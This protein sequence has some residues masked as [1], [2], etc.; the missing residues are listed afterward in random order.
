MLRANEV[1]I[2]KW[3]KGNSSFGSDASISAKS[4]GTLCLPLKECTPG[5]TALQNHRAKFDRCCLQHTWFQA[6]TEHIYLNVL[7][8]H[9]ALEYLW[10]GKKKTNSENTDNKIAAIM[11]LH[12]WLKISNWKENVC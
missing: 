2:R 8:D 5:I 3:Y 1:H 7:V 9:K 10:A 4:L 6:F 12:T 11:R